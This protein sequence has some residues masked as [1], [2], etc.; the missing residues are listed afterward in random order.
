[1]SHQKIINIY[2]QV[3]NDE[4]RVYVPWTNELKTVDKDTLYKITHKYELMA[5][6]NQHEDMDINLQHY[7]LDFKKWNDELFK[8][9]IDA[10]THS[11]NNDLAVLRAFTKYSS[12]DIHNKETIEEIE[13]KY[14]EACNNGYLESC[15][16]G[17]YECYGYDMNS[18]YPRLLGD[19]K[20]K[21]PIKAGKEYKLHTI[22]K[23]NLKFGF[24]KVVIECYHEDF[25]KIFK[26]SEDNTYTHYSLLFAYMYQKEYDI[27]IELNMTEEYNAYLYNDDDIIETK[28]I[29][30]TWLNKLI[31]VK[32][33]C[34]S[35]KLIKHLLSSLWGTLSRKNYDNKIAVSEKE[36]ENYDDEEYN[37]VD[38]DTQKNIYYVCKK[39]NKYKYNIRLKPF[40]QSYQRCFMGRIAHDNHFDQ[41]VRI[42]ADNITY[43][44]DVKID[45]PNF[46][47]E[48]KSSGKIQWKNARVFKKL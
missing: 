7:Y 39:Q 12:F 37:I 23:F 46:L 18:F 21:I 33:K 20:L 32:A 27:K 38:I 8:N 17:T 29:F 40:L 48:K 44:S 24:Y 25:V 34:K 41:I 28:S 43:K 22:D 36:L 3:K 4:Y 15:V 10:Y 14:F 11:Y 26:F 31:N 45:V 2:Y 5:G 42:F 1:M 47:P 19:S 6:Y 16:A 13:T 9:G 30:N 35:N